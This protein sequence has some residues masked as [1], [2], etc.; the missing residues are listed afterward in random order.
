MAGGV[1]GSAGSQ[2]GF[3]QLSQG[4]SGTI[5]TSGGMESAVAENVKSC[6]LG[7]CHGLQSVQKNHA[8]ILTPALPLAAALGK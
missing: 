1:G 7:A 8:L 4:P 3:P 2:A 5:R 6:P